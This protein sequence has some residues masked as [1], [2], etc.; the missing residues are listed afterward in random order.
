MIALRRSPALA[1]WL[2]NRA[3]A[4]V[5]FALLFALWEGAVWLFGNIFLARGVLHNA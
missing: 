3:G 4:L 2:R 1:A 5:L